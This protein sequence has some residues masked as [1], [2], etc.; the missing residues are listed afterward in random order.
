MW[1]LSTLGHALHVTPSWHQ[2]MHRDKSW[3]HEHYPLV[4]LRYVATAVVA[5]VLATAALRP[6]IRHQSKLAAERLQRQ[7]EEEAEALRHWLAAPAPPLSFPGRFTQKWLSENV[8]LLHPGQVPMLINELRA[9]GWS[10]VRIE[11]RVS[12]LVT[13]Y[14]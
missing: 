3:L 12:P 11:Q 8:P 4:G 13:R 9:R 1:P 7:Q 5:G 2:L 6:L 14:D 10:D